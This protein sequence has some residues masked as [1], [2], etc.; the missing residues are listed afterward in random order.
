MS[1]LSEQLFL[2]FCFSLNKLVDSEYSADN[3]KSFKI[4][5]GAIIIKQEMLRLIPDWLKT[6]KMYKIAVKKLLFVIKYAFD[7][8]SLNI[9]N[10]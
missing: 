9:R 2:L 7:Y 6:K 8:R 10:V 5:I 1:V 4:S 3:S